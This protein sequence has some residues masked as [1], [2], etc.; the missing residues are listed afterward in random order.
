MRSYQIEYLSFSVKQNN[1]CELFCKIKNTMLKLQVNSMWV[2]F[3]FITNVQWKFDATS[4]KKL[5]KM[6]VIV[7]FCFCY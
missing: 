3:P 2:D 4:I 7:V 6:N 5:L 1:N